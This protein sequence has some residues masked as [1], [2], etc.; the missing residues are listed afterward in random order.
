MLIS[1][2]SLLVFFF[3]I[4]NGVFVAPYIQYSEWIIQLCKQWMNFL[5]RFLPTRESL[6]KITITM[7]RTHKHT[8]L[9]FLSS[10]IRWTKMEMV[11][12][13]RKCCDVRKESN[14]KAFNGYRFKYDEK[15][16]L[17]FTK[18][19]HSKSLNNVNSN[20]FCHVFGTK[21]HYSS[22]PFA[23]T[24]TSISQSKQYAR[25]LWLSIDSSE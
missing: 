24:H 4:A 22:A 7:H 11:W 23:S 8:H 1:F 21:T 19:I 20:E 5:F 12:I 14:P 2:S 25:I 3:R 10:L 16:F 13:K 9:L 17:L 18:T 15:I 6:N